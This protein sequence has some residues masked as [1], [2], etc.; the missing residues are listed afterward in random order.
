MHKIKL[1]PHTPLTRA[2]MRIKLIPHTPL[3][4]A[5]MRKAW[6][7]ILFEGMHVLQQLAVG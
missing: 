6:L 2:Q 7:F 3:T 5:K 1:V 4:R